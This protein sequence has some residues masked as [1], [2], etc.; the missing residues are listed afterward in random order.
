[1]CG[2]PWRPGPA[3]L[4]SGLMR[5]W[6]SMTAVVGEGG[7]WSGVGGWAYPVGLRGNSEMG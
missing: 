5:S 4:T 7:G 3:V 2:A 1:M 6:M